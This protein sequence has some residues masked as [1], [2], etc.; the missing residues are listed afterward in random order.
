MSDQQRQLILSKAE[1]AHDTANIKDPVRMS[2]RQRMQLYRGKSSVFGRTADRIM[3]PVDRIQALFVDRGI[4]KFFVKGG[5]EDAAAALQDT[6]RILL[7]TGFTVGRDPVSGRALPETDGPVGTAEMAAKL[8]LAG[9]DMTIAT[10]SANMPVVQ[11]VLASLD[12][13]HLVKLE[14]FDAKRGQPARDAANELLDRVQPDAVVAIE[15]PARNADGDYLNM[16]GISVAE[17]N[18]P[19]DQIVLEANKRTGIVTVG[20]ATAVT[21]RHGQPAQQYPARH[22]RR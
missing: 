15:L 9:R 11:S 10:D 19:K 3:S 16:R 14:P 2:W 6:Q 8:A 5:T 4:R 13:G 22:A 7:V 12:G 21:G 17:V 1:F 18:A 20:W